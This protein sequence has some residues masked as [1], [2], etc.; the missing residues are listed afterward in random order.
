MNRPECFVGIDVSKASLDVAVRPT[1]EAWSTTSDEAGISAL[2]KRLQALAPTLIV[3]EATGGLEVALVSALAAAG[4]PVVVVN[5]RQVRD[6]AKATGRLAKTDAIDADVLA[7][8]AEAVRPEVRPIKDPQTQAL[9]ALI[10]RR[11]QLVDMLA[12][13]KNRLHGA[14]VRIRKDLQRHIVWLEKRLKEVDND[15]DKTIKASCVWRAKETLLLSAPGVGPVLTNTLIA[16]LPELGQLSR[17]QIAAL[18]GVA[19]F[20]HDSGKLR[21]RRRVWGGRS[22]LRC[23]LYMSTLTATRCNPVIRAFYQRLIQAGKAPKVALTACMRKLLIILNTML[24]NRTT[25]QVHA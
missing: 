24:K 20:N 7:R 21:G 1:G 6:F 23:V 25:W 18:A 9:A 19:P 8:F 17:R 15:L 22:E 10:T 4:L 3:M 2:I 5:P 16:L 11:R 14:P 13:E 12:A